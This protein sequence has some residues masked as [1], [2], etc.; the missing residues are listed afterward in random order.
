MLAYSL[1]GWGWNLIW[2]C[3]KSSFCQKRMK[4]TPKASSIKNPLSH[5]KTDVADSRSFGDFRGAQEK[6]TAAAVLA[7]S[8]LNSRQVII[9]YKKLGCFIDPVEIFYRIYLINMGQGKCLPSLLAI[10]L[11]MLSCRASGREII[12]AKMQEN[13][14]DWL[15]K[16]D[17]KGN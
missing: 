9:I 17:P 8:Q 3:N 13:N 12:C 10:N 4:K 14:G 1:I 11:Y 2:L 6:V 5:R 7:L 16:Q 15:I